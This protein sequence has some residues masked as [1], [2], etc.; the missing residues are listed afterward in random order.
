MIVLSLMGTPI[1]L[2][3]EDAKEPVKATL[4]N[5]TE[6]LGLEG[7]VNSEI[8]WVDYNDDIWTDLQ[9]GGRI[10]PVISITW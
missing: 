2:G 10:W 4:E 9:D 1:A 6:V 8:Y 5:V 7:L 3:A